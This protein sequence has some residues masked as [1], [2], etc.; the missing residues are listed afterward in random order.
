VRFTFRQFTFQE[1]TL[2]RAQNRLTLGRCNNFAAPS[3]KIPHTAHQ[4]VVGLE[5]VL[6]EM[7]RLEDIL[8][9]TLSWKVFCK[10]YC[11]G[12]H[13]AGMVKLKHLPNLGGNFTGM[14]NPLVGTPSEA[15]LFIP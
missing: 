9:K 13:F 3:N 7:G 1:E 2:C 10:S 15:E 6:Q 8:Q 12:R 4:G 5:G 11:V 14:Q